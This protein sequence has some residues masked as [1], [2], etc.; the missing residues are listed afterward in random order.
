MPNVCKAHSCVCP[1]VYYLIGPLDRVL[2]LI[3]PL[4]LRTQNLAVVVRLPIA[5]RQVS[6][7]GKICTPWQAS[8]SLPLSIFAISKERNYSAILD[9]Q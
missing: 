3:A 5:D 9:L 6:Q 1:R 8:S 4:W 7:L 2:P